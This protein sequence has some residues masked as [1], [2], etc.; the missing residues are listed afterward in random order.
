M[1]SALFIFAVIGFYILYTSVLGKKACFF[2]LMFISSAVL[3]LYLAGVAGV[4]NVGY[5]I[6][7]TTGCLM[8]PVL[9]FFTGKDRIKKIPLTLADPVIVFMIL[10]VIWIRFITRDRGLSNPDDFSHWYRMCKVIFYDDSYPVTPEIGFSTY[11]PGT[12]T[13]IYI[14]TKSFGFSIANCFTAQAALNMASV[15]VLFAVLAKCKDKL[16]KV[17]LGI[18]AAASFVFLTSVAVSTLSLAVDGTL[19]MVALGCIVF[20]AETKFDEKKDVVSLILILSFLVMVKFSGLFFL[21]AALALFI[22][23]KK[24]KALSTILVAAIPVVLNLLYRIRNSFIYADISQSRQASSVERFLDL[25]NDKSPDLIQNVIKGVIVQSVSFMSG[26][27]QVM[28]VWGVFF[29]FVLLIIFE[30]KKKPKFWFMYVFITYWVYVFFM[31]LMYI[32]S[33]S[34]EEAEGLGSFYRYM[35]TIAILVG[36]IFCYY[37]LN[38]FTSEK[39]KCFYL[40]VALYLVIAVLGGHVL[41][42]YDYLAGGDDYIPG[43][44]WYDDAWNA[45][46]AS[47]EENTE[48]TEDSYLVIWN[49][50]IWDGYFFPDFCKVDMM[51][52]FF[53]SKNIGF[54]ISDDPSSVEVPEGEYDHIVVV[55]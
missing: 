17:L 52:T 50:R 39:M 5:W 40:A 38:K 45:L 22:A 19:G 13:W 29:G 14:V 15:S 35:G 3:V 25:L 55:M 32:F 46:A 20:I 27:A 9:L 53:R 16:K 23:L 24:G 31:I 37:M 30:K 11:P 18:C 8:I 1:E 36:G 51:E 6:F 12:A 54:V 48:Y 4:L 49:Q 47:S 10:G 41:F 43:D 2:P 26:Y 21:A 44:L 34:V 28:L 42:N 7:I 33:M